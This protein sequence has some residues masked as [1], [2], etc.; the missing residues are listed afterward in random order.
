LN[1]EMTHYPQWHDI[2][3][4]TLLRCEK[5]HFWGYF[6]TPKGR[7]LS[8]ASPDPI[9]SYTLH[10]NN[11]KIFSHGH[12]IRTASL[13][14]LHPSP[15]PKRHPENAD[16]LLPNES[17]TWTIFLEEIANLDDISKS[18][19]STTKAPFVEADFYTISQNE[20]SNIQ[21]ISASKPD[22]FIDSPQN[23]QRKINTSKGKN[24]SYNFEFSPYDG[25]GEYKITVKD[26][27]GK[28]SEAI[29]N[30]R[31]DNYS[32]YIKSARVAC[33]KYPQQA[34]SHTESWYGF[35]PAYIAAE[36]FPDKELDRQVNEKF[37]E[38]YP[39]MYDT[40]TNI[41]IHFNHRIQ[42]HALMAALWAQRYKVSED[43]KHLRNA[44][45]LA[46]YILAQ[47]TPDG[48]YRSRN[49]HYTAV[50]YVAKAL[51]E[52]MEQEEPLRKESAE[53]NDNYSRHFHSVKK[54]VDELARN[55]DNIQ[56]EGQM[57]FEDGMISCSYTQISQFALLFPENS[58]ERIKYT[59]AA[60]KLAWMHRCL[61]QLK[62][63]D[64]RMHGGSLRYWEA[65]YDIL[66]SPNMMNSPHGWS[67]WRIYGLRNLYELT[68]KYD[69]LQQMI[70]SIGTCIK[71]IDPSTN[72]LNWAFIC[73]PYINAE[74][75]VPDTSKPSKG[76]HIKQ[77]IGEQYMPMISDWNTPAANTLVSGYWQYDGGK[78]DNDVHEIFKCLNEILLTKAYI[79]ELPDGSFK[80]FNCQIKKT[81]SGYAIVPNEDCINSIFCVV[82]KSAT[83]EWQKDNKLIKEEITQKGWIRK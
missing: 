78:C 58:E 19:F 64:A 29:I 14:L 80:T 21:I 13:D 44:A 47:Q 59:E 67:A 55:L 52:V 24:N 66:A 32:D 1:T 62:I 31:Y 17:K 22:V 5:T 61:A 36:Y 81:D 71:L 4:P 76:K 10:Y 56:T 12:L 49:T 70:N 83:F 74:I 57:T 82:N 46:D 38:L 3:F 41:P 20:K 68:G 63:P 15:L 73:D 16:R 2:F 37:D 30:C 65:Q 39:L 9:A 6:M 34:S 35:F 8:I 54:A 51:M 33:L 45:N 53:W 23:E 43:L 40:V 75:F 25:V 18:V 50:I 28:I 48:A 77:V 60:E 79:H 72:I 42:N 26:N 7:I 11:S 27:K 69:Y